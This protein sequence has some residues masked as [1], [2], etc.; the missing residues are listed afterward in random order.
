M[1]QIK[2]IVK[3][4]QYVQAFDEEVNQAL[5]A[6]WHLAKRDLVQHTLAA[7]GTLD[8]FYAEL[9]RDII[10]EAERNCDNCRHFDNDAD[11]EPCASCSSTA[12]NWEAV[13]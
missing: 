6:G 4:I 5:A 3:E 8:Y 12:S 1:L 10:T 13:E 9:V 2:T 7:R 11:A